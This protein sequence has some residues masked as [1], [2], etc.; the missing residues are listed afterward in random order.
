MKETVSDRAHE[1]RWGVDSRGK[2]QPTE[3]ILPPDIKL[4]TY[5]Q[6]RTALIIFA[7]IIAQMLSTRGGGILLLQPQPQLLLLS[8]QLQNHG[9][10]AQEDRTGRLSLQSSVSDTK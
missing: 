4:Q 5:L 6:L 2:V 8:L 9:S 10:N 1:V 3:K 7:P